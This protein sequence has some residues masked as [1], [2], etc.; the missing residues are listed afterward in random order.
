MSLSL[1]INPALASLRPPWDPRSK[2]GVILKPRISVFWPS[3]RNCASRNSTETQ[4][5][6]YL[7]KRKSGGAPLLS[8]KKRL[9]YRALS[10]M[11]AMSSRYNRY[12]KGLNCRGVMSKESGFV[13]LAA[14][15]YACNSTGR[16]RS[17]RPS[18][19]HFGE[20]AR[21]QEDSM[22]VDANP[23]H[24]AGQRDNREQ[25]Q[26]VA[27]R[28]RP[29]SDRLSAGH[30]RR[31]FVGHCD[32]V[33]ERREQRSLPDPE[34]LER[35]DPRQRARPVSRRTSQASS[36]TSSSLRSLPCAYKAAGTGAI[37]DIEQGALT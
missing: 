3:E 13:D 30:H 29:S 23:R 8:G 11:A 15:T 9:V 5:M 24:G 6:S 17:S 22:E 27:D 32:L 34:A 20:P 36:S 2:V 18:P 14:A 33:H 1:Y 28:L 7:G 26:R 25:Q 19:R 35:H 21:G 4:T 12:A 31:A 37:G 16:S 10:K